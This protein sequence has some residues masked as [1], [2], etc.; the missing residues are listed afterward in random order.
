MIAASQTD[1][2]KSMAGAAA[3]GDTPQPTFPSFNVH[4]VIS[5]KRHGFFVVALIELGVSKLV[6]KFRVSVIST[7]QVD[8]LNFHPF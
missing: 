7:Q 6:R 8:F 3:T 2:K 4:V 5:F 1:C